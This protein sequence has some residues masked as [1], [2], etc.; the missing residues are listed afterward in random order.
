[1]STKRAPIHVLLRSE[2]SA[3]VV[4][5]IE[6]GSLPDFGG[7]PLHHHDFDETFYVMEGELT[8]QL[9][10]ELFSAKAGELTFA[11]GRRAA[12]VGAA[13]DPRRHG[14]RPA[15]RSD[16]T[17]RMTLRIPSWWCMR[18]NPRL[19]SS[20]PIRCEMNESTSMS[21]AR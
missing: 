2:Q 17:Y 15:D 21:P 1:M 7:P 9:G 16:Q 12:R 13:A 8:F 14:R 4:S 10:D 3:G 18:S 11:P 20:R 6:S 5:M 19:I